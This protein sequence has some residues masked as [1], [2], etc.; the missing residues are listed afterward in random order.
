VRRTERPAPGAAP[1]QARAAIARG[2]AASVLA[3]QR[4]AGNAA[5]GRILTLQRDSWP[6]ARPGGW[7]SQNW[8]VAG[9]LRVVVKGLPIG[10]KG[11]D[12]SR[13]G[14]DDGKKFG[15]AT[16]EFAGDSD[17]ARAIV[18]VPEGTNFSGGK[19]EVLILYHGL[20][21]R[22][23]IAYRERS[24]PTAKGDAGIGAEGTVHDVENDLISQQL[25][26]SGRNMIAILPQGKATGRFADDRFKI[27]D[28]AAYVT[29]VLK[30]LKPEL[31]A[32]TPPIAVPDD[33]KPYRIVSA[34]HSGGGPYAV[35]AADSQQADW[36][37][38]SPLLLFDAINGPGELRTLRRVLTKWLEADMA[39]LTD[40]RTK[41]PEADLDR[42]GLK[43]RS[44]YST[45]S[46]EVYRKNHVGGD[47]ELGDGTKVHILKETEKYQDLVKDGMCLNGFLNH[48]FEDNAE[49]IVSAAILTKWKAQYVTTE[50][51]GSHHR[52]VGVGEAAGKT[53]RDTA[54]EGMTGPSEKAGVPQY[55]AGTGHLEQALKL[56]GPAGP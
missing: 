29:E 10:F 24:K 6:E 50:V 4:R 38:A 26:A 32:A 41:N 46:G 30:K 48:W 11:K 40:P 31:A 39:H 53:E 15:P 25:K 13:G 5:L 18:V 28:P 27:P 17:A 49:G 36:F 2:P 19:L 44:T 56:L 3:L 16:K 34:G 52:Q 12:V 8:T 21:A 9:T 47:Y 33:V 51:S 35:A 55:T 1:P 42:R 20:G 7:N 22:A 43:L 23:G 14:E 54:P 37:R 45:G